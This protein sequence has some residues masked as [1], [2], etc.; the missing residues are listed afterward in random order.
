MKNYPQV[1]VMVL[2]SSHAY[3][4]VD[5]R[6][7]EENRIRVFNM[8]SGMQ[9][10][11]ISYTLLN[12]YVDSLQPGLVLYSANPEVF[13]NAQIW[14]L[15][16]VLSNMP[17]NWP[18]VKRALASADIRVI[19]VLIFSL[20]Q[21]LTG[22][23]TQVVEPPVMEDDTYVKAGY[24][25]RKYGRYSAK[26]TFDPFHLNFS[27]RQIR[28]YQKM[29]DLL[30]QRHIPLVVF[31]SPI[32]AAKRKQCD[33]LDEFNALICQEDCNYLDYNQRCNFPD[34]L[35]YDVS[36]LNQDGIRLMNTD[37]IQTI[38]HNQLIQ[39]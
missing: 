33:N 30:H 5:P 3:K 6:I 14:S 17:P 26:T 2:G 22:Q 20:Y 16:D 13:D 24:V 27:S 35:F 36:H 37:I 4:G 38:I 10:P 23:A 18:V 39:Q 21:H 11:E 32:P 9:T 19:N 1:D 12:R 7:F 28:Y 25:E 34:T 29:C 8:G 15:M 31:Q